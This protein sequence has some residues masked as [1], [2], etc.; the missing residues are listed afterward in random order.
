MGHGRVTRDAAGR[1]DNAASQASGP[2]DRPGAAGQPHRRGPRS[3]TRSAR[4]L[5]WGV[6]GLLL[7]YLAA[8]YLVA[9]EA[10]GVY[11]RRHPALDAVPGITETADGIPGDPLNVALIGTQRDLKTAM[12]DAGWF[13]A[14]PLTFKSCLEIAEATVLRRPY[15]D[16]PV[17]NLYL[18][19][20]RED[21][22]FEQP[23]G[24]TP[25]SRHH[26][27]FWRV[28]EPDETGRPLWVGSAT[29]DVRV[30]LSETTGQVTHHISADLDAERD[31]LFEDLRRGGNLRETAVVRDFHA[32]REGRNGGGDPWRTDGSLLLGKLK[33]CSAAAD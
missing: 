29:F 3:W 32:V 14:D 11:E 33:P 28:P 27:R 21:L 24:D 13:P 6:A 20:R 9:P 30:G 25:R 2:S 1:E 16:A 23:V 15:D 4:R 12:L 26:V 10:W 5:A 22:A 19:G 8:A 18:R 17:S 7:L 31:H